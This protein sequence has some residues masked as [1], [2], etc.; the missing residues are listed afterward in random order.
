MVGD[1]GV[2]KTFTMD[3]AARMLTGAD[4]EQKI[5]QMIDVRAL[6]HYTAFTTQPVT[7]EDNDSLRKVYT[8]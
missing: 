4:E 3:V 1:K 5:N 6:L 8:I 2:G 7:L